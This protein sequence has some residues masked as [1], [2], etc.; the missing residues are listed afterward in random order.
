MFQLGCHFLQILKIIKK[1]MF[2]CIRRVKVTIWHMVGISNPQPENFEGFGGLPDNSVPEGCHTSF[3]AFTRAKTRILH[4]AGLTTFNQEFWGVQ[5]PP[6]T[7]AC[8]RGAMR[9]L[10]HLDVYERAF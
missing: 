3:A 4:Y 8:Q 9:L 6:L 10:N 5:G 1:N 7:I 2:F